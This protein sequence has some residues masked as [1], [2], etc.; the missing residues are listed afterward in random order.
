MTL[1]DI[2]A[3]RPSS[4]DSNTYRAALAKADLARKDL[5][6]KAGELARVR[7]QGRLNVDDKTLLKA[8]QDA[9]A[10]RLAIERIDAIL[11]M[12]RE[13]LSKAE[14]AE[15]LEE[16]RAGAGAVQKKVAAL[17][18]WQKTQFPKLTAIM[19]EGFRLQDEAKAERDAYLERV[20]GEYARP[21]V[22]DAGPLGVEVPPMPGA[23]PREYFPRWQLT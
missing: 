20:R 18:A 10:A 7:A 8:E 5:T 22:R 15:T 1:E 9:A 6:V 13:D 2:L 3:L 23:L 17:E 16:L 21:E 12:I 11:P 14:G 4:G 19:A